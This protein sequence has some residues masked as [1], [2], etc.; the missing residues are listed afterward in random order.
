MA[1]KVINFNER[2]MAKEND[3]WQTREGIDKALHEAADFLCREYD[4]N[5]EKVLA[6]KC[7]AC[8]SGKDG[9]Y[10]FHFVSTVP[11]KQRGGKGFFVYN[12]HEK[13]VWLLNN[14][15][16]PYEYSSWTKKQMEFYRRK[17]R[18][19]NT[20]LVAA[21]IEPEDDIDFIATIDEM[22]AELED[23][24]LSPEEKDEVEQALFEIYA[25][26]QEDTSAP[27][28]IISDL[29]DDGSDLAKHKS[30]QRTVLTFKHRDG[31]ISNSDSHGVVPYPPKDR[32]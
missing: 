17:T 8:E 11:P 26:L 21:E 15:Y 22:I 4:F 24:N 5:R 13:K 23:G 6:S 14:P 30:S 10:V 7:I 28:E 32:S 25:I 19:S 1:E 29:G 18:K 20:Q 9:S 27:G 12:N 31:R 2:K 3:F 16:V